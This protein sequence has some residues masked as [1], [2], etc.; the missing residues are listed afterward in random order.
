[1]SLQT[2]DS[3]MSP[4]VSEER[5]TSTSESTK[6]FDLAC[7]GRLAVDLYGE[8]RGVSLTETTSFRRYLGGSSGNLAVGASR[9]GLSVAMIS[10]VGDDSMGRYLRETLRKAGVDD[11]GL[12]TRGD[13][14]TAL[15]FLGMLGAEAI[16]LDFYREKAADTALELTPEVMAVLTNARFVAVCG[17]HF[18]DPYSN[19]AVTGML[20]TAASAG[21]R[22]VLDIDLRR[23][24]WSS[25]DGGFAGSVAR[26]R[27]AASK[28]AILVGNEEEMLALTGE[29]SIDAALMHLR[30]ITK[31]AIVLKQ[32]ARGA[33]FLAPGKTP[34]AENWIGCEGFSV[35]LVNPVGAGDAFLS[36]FLT[37]HATG[38]DPAASL[39]RGNAAG[40][41]VVSRHACSEAMPSQAELDLFIQGVDAKDKRIDH[42]HRVALRRERPEKILAFACDHRVPFRDLLAKYGGSE[43]D[44]RHFKELTV[45]AALRVA[46]RHVGMQPAMLMDDTFG[47]AALERLDQAGAWVGRPVE[48]TRSRPLD[49]ETGADIAEAIRAWNPRHVA[50]C[51]VWHHPDDAEE[52]RDR[53]FDRIR[54]L[55][56]ASHAANVE[57]M[58]ESIPPLEVGYSDDIL[59]QSVGQVYAAGFMPDYWKLPAL[60]TQDG[61]DRLSDLIEENDPAC[62][63]VV[64]LG[65]DRSFEELAAGLGLA[66]RQH[67]CAGFAIG[68]T[69]FGECAGEWFADRIDD[70]TAV[71]RMADIY[72]R[73]VSI[74]TDPGP[75]PY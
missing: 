26:C 54:Q 4:P 69:L 16:G 41:L 63:G 18:C 28:S 34:L 21:A 25:F 24:L 55:Q 22:I 46:A 19:S 44:V 17:T 36:G 70:G 48:L 33:S 38:G 6:R 60:S 3:Q 29:P 10:A 45:D 56:A 47:V 2:C 57:W 31:A 53:Q 12:A 58:L 73:V 39:R 15:A 75:G 68:R 13:R 42:A 71:D 7:V 11:S 64:V 72:Q 51:L 9:L 14:R 50:K 37:S 67:G 32:G 35:T 20:R 1:M 74:F 61:W 49:F 59:I 66:A 65:L 8:Q 30:Q 23:D 62:R 5:S 43:D 27:Q 40:A 52:L